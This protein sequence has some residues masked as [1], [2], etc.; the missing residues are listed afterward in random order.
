M[1][2]RARLGE[3]LLE[4]GEIDAAQLAAALR[5]HEQTG[6]PLGLTLVD[7]GAL[8]EETL[9][10]T[11]SQQLSLPMAR[12][13]GKRVG[14]EV[15]EQVPFDLAEKHR[16]FPLFVKDEGTGRALYLGMEDASD[17]DAI[18]ALTGHTGMTIRPVLVAPSEIEEALH[19]QYHA[20]AG[21]VSAPLDAPESQ[22]PEEDRPEPLPPPPSDPGFDGTGLSADLDLDPGA[23][24]GG[25]L[26]FDSRGLE[27][28]GSEDAPAGQADFALTGETDFAS[29]GEADDPEIGT[30]TDW[31]AE[32][33]PG[34]GELDVDLDSDP[35]LAD[36]DLEL[37]A[38]AEPPPAIPEPRADALDDSLADFAPE[39][40]VDA[41]GPSP[42]PREPGPPVA[43]PEPVPRDAILRALTQLLV[44]KGLIDR[45][46]L[47]ARVH[48]ENGGDGG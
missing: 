48:R 16:C 20:L 5:R 18:E 42:L 22:E 33:E 7:M 36:P 19:R 32:P 27:P 29:A 9:V 41:P 15:L 4:A 45:E 35:E 38:E 28:A 10:R 23:L 6:R 37:D 43:G 31:D 17:L 11:L 40:E 47:I 39:L 8:Q 14:V 26:D 34:A 12:L 44:E 2:A 3:I 24:S 46:E 21:G 13:E 25:D 1:G 30:H